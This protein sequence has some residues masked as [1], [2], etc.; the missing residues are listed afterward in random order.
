MKKLISFALILGFIVLGCADEPGLLT[1]EITKHNSG[2]NWIKLP[3]PEG[4]TV[5]AI[6]SAEATIDGSQGGSLILE[7]SY[8]GGIHGTVTHYATLEIPAGAFSG[9]ML[10]TMT[11]DDVETK[12]T[13]TPHYLFDVP[14]TYNLIY[15][16]LKLLW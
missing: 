5:N 10:I 6:Y 2:A 11:T 4:L 7:G 3:K 13:F 14:L 12:S 9:E 8:Q 16:G 15:T 1:P